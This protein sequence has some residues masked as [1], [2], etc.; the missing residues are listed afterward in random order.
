MVDDESA[1]VNDGLAEDVPAPP[2]T[3]ESYTPTL[4]DTLLV[5]ATTTRT[6]EIG[7]TVDGEKDDTKLVDESMSSAGEAAAHDVPPLQRSTL[8]PAVVKRTS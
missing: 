7:A 1:T 6:P 2:P 3:L 5:Q 4:Q 8:V